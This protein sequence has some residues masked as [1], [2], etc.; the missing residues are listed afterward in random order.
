MTPQRPQKHPDPDT[1]GVKIP[2]KLHQETAK[3]AEGL[4]RENKMIAVLIA[5]RVHLVHTLLRR[6]QK[7]NL[8]INKTDA[9]IMAAALKSLTGKRGSKRVGPF[10]QD[11][12][13]LYREHLTLAALCCE[14]PETRALE[15]QII[16]L[17]QCLGMLYGRRFHPGDMDRRIE[18]ARAARETLIGK[19]QA[20]LVTASGASAR[21][22]ACDLARRLEERAEVL[23][24]VGQRRGQNL[25]LKMDR[26][27]YDLKMALR[28]PVGNRDVVYH[29]LAGTTVR[30][31]E[32]LLS[33]FKERYGR[34]F[35][36]VL[37]QAYGGLL[38]KV[39]N[40]FRIPALRASLEE[41]YGVDVG[42][43]KALRKEFIPSLGEFRAYG[44]RV[45]GFLDSL[46]SNV[47][48]P[49]LSRIQALLREDRITAATDS[50]F[51][52]IWYNDRAS[53]GKMSEVLR[54]VNLDETRNMERQ[55]TERYGKLLKR[56]LRELIT[57][58]FG[59]LEQRYL[60]ARLEAEDPRADAILFHM[61]QGEGR[62]AFIELLI[63]LSTSSEEA[64]TLLR[65]EYREEF[66]HAI[67]R[68][69]FPE[70]MEAAIVDWTLYLLEGRRIEASAARLRCA[71]MKLS[72]EW[73]GAVFY[74]MPAS[75][76]PA[77]VNAYNRQYEADF[78]T[79]FRRTRG[80]E[81]E[82]IMR[83]YVEKGEIGDAELLR[84][85]LVGF[86]HDVTGLKRCFQGKTRQEI[87]ALAQEYAHR[88]RRLPVDPEHPSTLL[89][90]DYTKLARDTGAA[91]L[92][93]FRRIKAS[94][95][96]A[97]LG[98]FPQEWL[99]RIRQARDLDEDLA[100]ELSGY[101]YHDI[102]L[103]R[104][105]KPEHAEDQ[106][107]NFMNCYTLEHAGKELA[108]ETLVSRRE[109]RKPGFSK[110]KLRS[111][112]AIHDE[113][114]LALLR[115]VESGYDDKSQF[116]VHLRLAQNQLQIRREL[117]RRRVD[118]ASN[119]ASAA[120]T[121]ATASSLAFLSI[122]VWHA[123][124]IV[125]LAS[126]QSRYLL[127]VWLQGKGYGREEETLDKYLGA[128]DGGTLSLAK[129]FKVARQLRF[130]R[131][132]RM[133]VSAGVKLAM[134]KTLSKH[135]HNKLATALLE[136][137]VSGHARIM[138]EMDEEEMRGSEGVESLQREKLVSIDRAR[139]DCYL[140]TRSLCRRIG[141]EYLRAD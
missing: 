117:Q 101:N 110:E 114:V 103:L 125:G 96:L 137:R 121:A 27:A 75:A 105:G 10:C 12:S 119:L 7:L 81:R 92:A 128:V 90:L 116:R 79:E 94:G 26:A 65:R 62:H 130:M 51:L 83:H 111:E 3:C 106:M 45:K 87:D 20:L 107:A 46:A 91:L 104:K 59:D 70:K 8:K 5:K 123:M 135:V 57:D 76:A 118:M 9:D 41:R 73:P 39:K 28:D 93:V 112:Q 31:R 40:L 67:T 38:P 74:A 108:L 44:Q 13:A 34:D 89:T 58:R 48:T 21:T 19:I 43:V 115:L 132:A 124:P 136:E 133:P 68:E 95:W 77:I 129:W 139:L 80:P 33:V 15:A 97:A 86:G 55:F 98:T 37:A 66:G 131:V 6:P 52:A 72:G 2:L 85:C 113:D 60:L 30:E 1:N 32:L 29:L 88:F 84:H 63:E 78:W 69:T 42:F 4:P 24:E 99:S 11:L 36:D 18:Q 56:P 138:T 23:W 120:I 122:P 50:I 102:M 47:A 82:A 49:E 71:T 54:G 16:E 126:F 17:G 14:H 22:D 64:V 109:R 134:K 141:R 25:Y 35:S 140:N 127:R 100:L 61:R 53:L